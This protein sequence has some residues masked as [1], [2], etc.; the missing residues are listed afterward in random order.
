MFQHLLIPV[1]HKGFPAGDKQGYWVSS[2]SLASGPWWWG[3][4]NPGLRWCL[5]VVAG[6]PGIM[7][8]TMPP[9]PHG[10]VTPDYATHRGDQ[11]SNEWQQTWCN[12]AIISSLWAIF[13]VAS[14]WTKQYLADKK[15]RY[16]RWG[17]FGFNCGS[18]HCCLKR[19]NR[20]L[21]ERASTLHN[22]FEKVYFC[23]TCI[24]DIYCYVNVKHLFSVE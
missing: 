16:K 21:Y 12:A 2:N 15:H 20:R 7:A 8:V 5:D 19:K 9:P 10:Q 14:N 13:C 11:A 3:S 1:G 18:C 22:C 23:H 6:L 24:L 4:N 17:R